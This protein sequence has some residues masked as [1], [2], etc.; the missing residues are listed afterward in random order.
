MFLQDPNG[1]CI[2]FSKGIPG[3]GI[4]DIY[5]CSVYIFNVT[6][7]NLVRDSGA[8]LGWATS[9]NESL[10]KTVLLPIIGVC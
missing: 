3:T 2:R 9:V 8:G 6:F 4:D 1:G 7:I 5:D 10:S